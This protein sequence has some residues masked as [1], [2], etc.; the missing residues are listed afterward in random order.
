MNLKSCLNIVIGWMLVF[1]CVVDAEVSKCTQYSECGVENQLALIQNPGYQP[2]P[3]RPEI[4]YMS[5]SL[6]I[7]VP[8]NEST[9]GSSA[10]LQAVVYRPYVAPGET[11][12]PVPVVMAYWPYET[13]KDDSSLSESD[14][15]QERLDH[16]FKK[17]KYTLENG[18][19]I[20]EDL[21]PQ[22]WCGVPIAV[23]EVGTRRHTDNDGKDRHNNFINYLTMHDGTKV[24]YFEDTPIDYYT[25]AAAIL[26]WLDAQDWWNGE[27][28]L[29]GSSG[30]AG[31]ESALK[32]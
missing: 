25:D 12:T 27:I 24:P 17:H 5:Y 31:G 9:T 4:D 7:C 16:V 15:I 2:D 3:E 11:P 28:F 26:S 20:E 13:Y 19:L 23:M 22:P 21:G 6:C 10:K 18:E 30:N 14:R 32:N 8:A 1:V 29:Y